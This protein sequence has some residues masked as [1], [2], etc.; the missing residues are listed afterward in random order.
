MSDRQRMTGAL[1]VDLGEGREIKHGERAGQIRYTRPPRA[2]Y[3]CLLCQTQ[4]G[5][6]EGPETV[7]RFVATVRAVHAARC[8]AGTTT[9]RT[10]A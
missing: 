10:A 9:E 1:A 4:E 7:R 5:P 3:A 2:V 6:V 8:T